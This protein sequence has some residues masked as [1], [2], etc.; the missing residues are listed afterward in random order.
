M[1]NVLRY[2]KPL[3]RCSWIAIAGHLIDA[4]KPAIR[5]H[6]TKTPPEGGIDVAE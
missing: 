2:V 1:R 5:F 3:R 6:Q 4:N